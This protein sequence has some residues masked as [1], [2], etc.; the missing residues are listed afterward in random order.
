MSAKT[1]T[2]SLRPPAASPESSGRLPVALIA[3]VIPQGS[4][5]ACS[6]VGRSVALRPQS[7]ANDAGVACRPSRRGAFRQPLMRLGDEVQV[8]ARQAVLRAQRAA[9]IFGAEQPALLQ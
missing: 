3:S 4:A 5:P 1:T 9:G 7:R 8:R 2:T 6:E